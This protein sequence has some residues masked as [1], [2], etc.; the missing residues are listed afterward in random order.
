MIVLLAVDVAV[1]VADLFYGGGN[2]NHR[3]ERV[4]Y[5]RLGASWRACLLA[6]RE[7]TLTQSR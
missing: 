1:A 4:H 3:S 6:G 5:L 7:N 2:F